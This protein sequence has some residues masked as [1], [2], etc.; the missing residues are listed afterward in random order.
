MFQF[1]VDV[2]MRACDLMLVAIG[3]SAVYSLMKFPN[4]A[5]VQYA[6]TG[7][8]L[9]IVLQKI[10]APV[11]VAIVF[12]VVLTGL[13]AVILNEFL[14]N[15]MLKIGSSTAM[16]GSLAVSLVFSAAFLVTVGPNPSR[17]RLPVSK[18]IRILDA[19][20]TEP[21]LVSFAIVAVA[22]GVF[23]LL[24]FRTDLGR[25]MRATST[26]EVLADATG[27]NTARMK[28]II[29]LIS[30][31]MA[32]L[33]GVAI[34]L[35]GEVD[36]QIGMDLLLPVFASAILGGLGNPFGA[37]AGAL[38]ISLVETVVTTINFGPLMGQVVVFLPVA[39]ASAIS[40]LLLVAA[41]LWR[42][43]GL[44]VSEVKRV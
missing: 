31:V 13:V 6:A 4:I 35:K 28:T 10:G 20:I 19:R 38:L 24:Y 41:L 22:L 16:I 26:N 30:G 5:L 42:P 15:R 33:G 37:V 44:F 32:A 1:L 11:A 9:A 21:Q 18:P 34:A 40:F 39:Y 27:I 25:C 17:F 8:I 43:R 36:I 14:F 3:M 2:L 7:G 23:A 12:A 29:V